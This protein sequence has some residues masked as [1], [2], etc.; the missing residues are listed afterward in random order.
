MTKNYFDY[1]KVEFKRFFFSYL[2]MLL[3]Y[4]VAC[5]VSEVQ[6]NIAAMISVTASVA[7]VV[8]L[9]KSFRSYRKKEKMKSPFD[10]F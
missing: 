4:L 3:L 10:W 7:I 5:R 1:L 2:A 6:Q 9:I 8:V